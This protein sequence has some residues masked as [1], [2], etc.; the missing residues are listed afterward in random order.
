MVYFADRTQRYFPIATKV[1]E[2]AAKGLVKPELADHYIESAKRI[3]NIKL[4]TLG[5]P[6]FP[7]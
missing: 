7:A 1:V 3:A 4:H 6:E 5:F 2:R